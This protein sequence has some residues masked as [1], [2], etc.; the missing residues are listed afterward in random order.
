VRYFEHERHQNLGMSA[1]RNLGIRNSRGDYIALL[2][3]DDVWLSEKLEQQVEIIES[4]P[5]AAMVYGASQYWYSWTGNAQ[6][7]Q[8]DH[9]RPLGVPPNALC[10][11]PTL[12]RLALE[13]KAPTPCPSALL[14]RRELLDHVGGFEE[15][16]RGAYEDQ[17]FLAKVYLKASVFVAGQC[18]DRYRQ[19]PDSS[20]SV[21]K[22]NG[23][24]YSVGLF[25]LKWLKKYLLAQGIQD[26]ELW[27]ALRSKRARYR[28]SVV[29][30]YLRHPQDCGGYITNRLTSRIFPAS[31][32]SLLR[33]R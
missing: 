30:Q 25:Y 13:S 1:S 10:K 2:D 21:I 3:A 26:D 15:R 32:R 19:H 24:K 17:A 20:V 27:Q 14:M 33:A 23:Q 18:W 28:R 16:F 31:L 29:R 11:P 22:S 9:V 12:L 6:E 4:H 5:E 7:L 8:R